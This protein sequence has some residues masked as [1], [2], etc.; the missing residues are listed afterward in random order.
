MTDDINDFIVEN[1]VSDMEHCIDDVDSAIH[2]MEDFRS[3]FREKHRELQTIMQNDDYKTEFSSEPENMVEKMK[4]YI[5]HMKK[6]RKKVRTQGNADKLEEDE[7]KNK[8]FCFL[9]VE[10]GEQ[11]SHL[12]SE[13]NKSPDALSDDDLMR[14]K[15]CALEIQ[16]R[17]DLIWSKLSEMMKL[18]IRDSEMQVINQR[19]RTL[20]TSKN[21]YV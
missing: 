18:N 5:L 4:L 10:M 12:E 7:A 19:Y 11:I 17:L 1:D 9:Y 3:T 21:E 20:I 14:K 13:V 2:R 8:Y 6:I 15:D 16:K